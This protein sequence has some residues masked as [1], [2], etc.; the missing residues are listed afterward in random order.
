[1]LASCHADDAVGTF[2]EWLIRETY[3]YTPMVIYPIKCE[4]LHWKALG[5]LD[6]KF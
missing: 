6:V 1:M 5:L 2:D 4:S 3:W